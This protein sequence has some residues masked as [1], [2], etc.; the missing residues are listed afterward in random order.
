MVRESDVESHQV[1]QPEPPLGPSVGDEAVPAAGTEAETRPPQEVELKVRVAPD[2]MQAFLTMRANPPEP[3]PFTVRSVT[4]ALSQAGVTKGV[5]AKEV[6]QVV[7]RREYV[8]NWLVARGQPAGPG[9]DAKIELLFDPSPSINREASEDRLDWRQVDLVQNVV[10]DQPLARKTPAQPGPPGLT[11]TGKTVPPPA[12]RDAKLPIGKG[13]RVSEQDPNT[14]V[15]GIDGAVRMS[16][17]QVIVENVLRVP[18]AVDFSVGNIDFRGSVV[19]GDNVLPGFHVRATGDIQIKGCVEAATIESGGS[20]WVSQGVFGQVDVHGSRGPVAAVRA[21][22][23]VS[24]KFARNAI[25]QA[26]GDINI[27]LEA[28][29]CHMQSGN[30]VAVGA[31]EGQKGRIAGG[32]VTAVKGV[33]AVD[34]GAESAVSTIVTLEVKTSAIFQKEMAEARGQLEAARQRHAEVIKRVGTLMY[35]RAAEKEDWSATQEE[36]LAKLSQVAGQMEEEAQ[37]LEEQIAERTKAELPQVVVYGKLYPGV[38]ITIGSAVRSFSEELAH[39][40]VVPTDDHKSIVT[41]DARSA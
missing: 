1:S 38:R 32:Q 39:V 18:R 22:K 10:Q 12:A 14:L 23:N 13:T 7:A 16:G 3:Y 31:A 24:A 28:I 29:N 2:E 30:I 25:I 5:L 6:I 34:L 17:G 11:V 26:A 4:E 41:V 20:V 21:A 15:A 33:R 35:K 9:Q 8:T 40:R 27:E 37:V 19:I 36:L